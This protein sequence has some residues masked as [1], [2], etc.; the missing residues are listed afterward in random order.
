MG[1]RTAWPAKK[2]AAEEAIPT[3]AVM[4]PTT[5]AL[6]ASTARR[7]GAAA[8]VARIDPVAYS[9]VIVSTP[10]TPMA[11]WARKKPLRL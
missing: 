5:T 11:S 6:A 10:S 1:A 2:A 3:R 4:V 7:W 8:K 9:L